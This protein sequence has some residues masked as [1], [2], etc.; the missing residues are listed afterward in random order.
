MY[1]CISVVLTITL[2]RAGDKIRKDAQVGAQTDAIADEFPRYVAGAE[3]Y[4]CFR[5]AA[6]VLHIRS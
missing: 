3:R 5:L 2:L 1:S 4:F 6:R